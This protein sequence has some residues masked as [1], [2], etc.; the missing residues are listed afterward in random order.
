MRKKANKLESREMG[1]WADRQVV[2]SQ[3]S[4]QGRWV[5]K[6]TDR[7][8]DKQTDKETDKQMIK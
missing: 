7:Q 4:K 1:I 6:K 3:D 2:G 5:S 8:V